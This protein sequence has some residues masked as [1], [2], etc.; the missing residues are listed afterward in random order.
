M[1]YSTKLL[2]AAVGF[3][4]SLGSGRTDSSHYSGLWGGRSWRARTVREELCNEALTFTYS[5]ELDRDG[6]DCMLEA[7]HAPIREHG[8][9]R[10][11]SA[12]EESPLPFPALVKLSRHCSKTPHNAHDHKAE[13]SHQNYWH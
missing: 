9:I 12:L 3:N 6:V 7:L 8:F 5:L 10:A 2:A 11:A 1:N 13:Y 4:S